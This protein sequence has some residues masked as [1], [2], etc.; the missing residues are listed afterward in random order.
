MDGVEKSN[1]ERNLEKSKN[2]NFSSFKKKLLNLNN[3]EFIKD[4]NLIQAAIMKNGPEYF[5][6]TKSLEMLAS[7]VYSKFM[8]KK[9][10]E[11]EQVGNGI[12]PIG[13]IIES[14]ASILS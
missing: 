6:E 9:E 13:K 2:T 11:K 12:P 8:I 14:F 5:F 10:S 4:S 3:A 7:A 1:A